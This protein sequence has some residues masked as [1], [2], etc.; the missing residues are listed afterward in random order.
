LGLVVQNGHHQGVAMRSTHFEEA[1]EVP[2]VY[3]I[4]SEKSTL[5]APMKSKSTEKATVRRSTK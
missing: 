2:L 3:R 5:Q 4:R 1:E